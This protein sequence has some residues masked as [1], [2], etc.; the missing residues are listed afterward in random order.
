MKTVTFCGHGNIP[1][2]DVEKIKP[3]LYNKIETLIEAQGATEFLLGGYGDFDG[4]AARVVKELK[5]KY[6]HITSTLVI[7]YIDRDYNKEL[8]DG[9]VFPPIESVPKRFAISKRNEW[10]VQSADFVIAYVKYSWGGASTTLDYA[11]RKKKI[12]FNIADI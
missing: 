3:L 5:V 6:P 8:Y 10:M 9:S 7:P 11:R 2:A 4:T 12:I 1:S